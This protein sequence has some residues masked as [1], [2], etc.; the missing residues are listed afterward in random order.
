MRGGGTIL[1]KDH[2]NA[3]TIVDLSIGAI[4][5]VGLHRFEFSFGY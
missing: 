5:E 2:S 1:D 3:M 4:D